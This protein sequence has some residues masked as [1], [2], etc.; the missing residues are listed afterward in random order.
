MYAAL[1]QLQL[2]CSDRWLRIADNPVGLYLAW[3][4]HVPVIFNWSQILPDAN[5]TA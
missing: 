3:S 4:L 1:R 2:P 5:C